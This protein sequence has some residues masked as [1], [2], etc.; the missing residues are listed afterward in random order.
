MDNLTQIAVLLAVG[1]LL[2]LGGIA[3]LNI[4]SKLKASATPPVQV[5]LDALIPWAQKAIVAGEK[6]AS[7]AL[8][9]VDRELDGI[10]KAA[11]ADSIYN[12][13]PEFINVGGVSIPTSLVKHLVTREMFS[14][15]VKRVY[16]ETDAFIERN[17]DYLKKQI[18]QS[19]LTSLEA[20]AK[21]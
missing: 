14:D 5:I 19:T 10:D 7:E 3:V 18:P 11:V 21:A 20:S 8:D 9:E 4:L 12:L 6:A 13:L 17:S 2:I 1:G 15:L 16:D